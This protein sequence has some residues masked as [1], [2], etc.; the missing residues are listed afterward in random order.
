MIRF[1]NCKINLGLYITNRRADG[2][3]DLET[4][5]YPVPLQDALEMIAAKE[6]SIHLTGKAVSG[7]NQDNLVWKAL[8]LLKQDF[9][10]KT[11]DFEIHLHKA[12]PMGAGMGGGS[13]DGAFALAML[14]DLC[15]LKLPKEQLAVY[16]LQLG[17]DCPF[18]IYNTPQ[19]ASGRGE[20]M[21]P[22]TLDLSKYSLQLVCPN[23]HVATGKAFSM[24]TP[25][26]APFDL[27]T[28]GE[29][30]VSKWKHHISN[31]FE[32]PIFEQHPVLASI[33]QQL[34]AAGAV[35]ASMSG[36]G[37]TVFG[38]FEKG[39]KAIFEISLETFYFE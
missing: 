6:S 21:Q 11:G 9:P 12:I 28:I 22:V 30:P 1:P 24:I 20:K 39:R 16:A 34:Y 7:N 38:I 15:S 27:R 17:S 18:F 37:S 4:V 2:Y 31:D 8:Q 32:T 10:E 14:N 35:Y 36:S 33:K 13:A 26:P 19:F 25:R 23:V 3:H 5:F 29:L